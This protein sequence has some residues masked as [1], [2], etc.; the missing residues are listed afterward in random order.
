MEKAIL[1]C[2]TMIYVLM[3]GSSVMAGSQGKVACLVDPPTNLVCLI[4]F[5]TEQFFALGTL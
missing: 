1:K 5:S 3:V 4:D 2:L